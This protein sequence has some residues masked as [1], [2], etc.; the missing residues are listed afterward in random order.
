MGPP[1]QGRLFQYSTANIHQPEIV[2]FPTARLLLRD[3]LP[4]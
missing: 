4:T 2:G 1:Y 3:E